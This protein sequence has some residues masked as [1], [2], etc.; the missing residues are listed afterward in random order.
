M[1]GMAN[2][3][4]ISHTQTEYRTT[5]V[6]PRFLE[7]VNIEGHE[8][9]HRACTDFGVVQQ[10][11]TPMVQLVQAPMVVVSCS[12][13]Q[14]DP[15]PPVTAKPPGNFSQPTGPPGIFFEPPEEATT[16][17]QELVDQQRMLQEQ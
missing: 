3:C 5:Q 6:S 11:M 4:H 8:G 15:L 13:A 12:T 2:S 9:Q 10:A 1:A 17:Q 14:V 7:P 16:E